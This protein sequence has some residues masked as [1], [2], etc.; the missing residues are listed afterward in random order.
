ML[1]IT[2]I[3]SFFMSFVCFRV[4]NRKWKLKFKDKVEENLWHQ[5]HNRSFKII[6]IILL[7]V[8]IIQLFRGIIELCL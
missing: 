8:G 2:S 7:I 1:V 3:F 6:A 4:I 5:E